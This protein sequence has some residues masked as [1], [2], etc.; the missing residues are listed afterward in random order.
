[1]TA[2]LN[3]NL[4]MDL[5]TQPS[6]HEVPD[7]VPRPTLYRNV[8]EVVWDNPDAW[9]H[10]VLDTKEMRSELSVW[11]A[12]ASVLL[13]TEGLMEVGHTL[14]IYKLDDYTCS[15]V[16]SFLVNHFD[17]D[18]DDGAS[19]HPA[20]CRL[21]QAAEEG[22][23]SR[24]TKCCE[25]ISNGFML[26][27]LAPHTS[28]YCFT[29]TVLRLDMIFSRMRATDAKDAEQYLDGVVAMCRTI[30]SSGRGSGCL[31]NIGVVEI[32]LSIRTPELVEALISFVDGD[33]GNCFATAAFSPNPL[34]YRTLVSFHPNIAL[35]AITKCL[36]SGRYQTA[37]TLLEPISH[38]VS[39]K[40]VTVANLI[41]RSTPQSPLPRPLTPIETSYFKMEWKNNFAELLGFTPVA[42]SA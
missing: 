41:D 37:Y 39:I 23:V 27:T 13:Q 21:L 33:Y 34:T 20:T 5:S 9:V 8:R 28:F 29:A 36:L 6:I 40:F 35:R 11:F 10:K 18:A 1:M 15:R 7:T 42:P 12:V 32:A 26:G 19:I 25:K 31:S 4:S 30:V 22:N 16:I 2:T 14:M 17:V 38:F 3:G 24:V